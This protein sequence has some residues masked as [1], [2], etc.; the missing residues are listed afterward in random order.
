MN[1]NILIGILPIAT[2]DN[3]LMH[4]LQKKWQNLQNGVTLHFIAQIPLG[5]LFLTISEDCIV[6]IIH[7]VTIY[8]PLIMCSTYK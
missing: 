2:S 1:L 8:I 6:M 4:F 3:T 7:A 5:L